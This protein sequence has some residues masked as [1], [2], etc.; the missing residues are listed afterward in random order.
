M[1]ERKK[2]SYAIP[3]VL[4]F[5]LSG[6]QFCADIRDVY[7][8]LDLSDI[9]DSEKLTLQKKTY[10][11]YF[12]QQIPLINFYQKF[13]LSRN[14]SDKDIRILFLEHK[15]NLLCFLTDRIVEFIAFDEKIAAQKILTYSNNYLQ[16]DKLHYDNKTFLFPNYSKILTNWKNSKLPKKINTTNRR[17]VMPGKNTLPP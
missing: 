8:F 6:Q 17:S 1:R 16:P 13:K 5:E 15:G 7:G 3:G 4:V 9:N 12:N 2:K 14:E 11:N 10:F